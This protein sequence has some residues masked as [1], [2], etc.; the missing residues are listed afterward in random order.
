MHIP[1]LWEP[2]GTGNQISLAA[3][4]NELHFVTDVV[5]VKTIDKISVIKVIPMLRFMKSDGITPLPHPKNA[6]PEDLWQTFN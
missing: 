3:W 4:R 2:A 1:P 5:D 6:P